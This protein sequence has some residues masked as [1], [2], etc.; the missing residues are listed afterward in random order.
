[1]SNPF[2]DF[3]LIRVVHITL[4]CPFE[5]AT[6]SVLRRSL[7]QTVILVRGGNNRRLASFAHFQHILVASSC[8][9]GK[10]SPMEK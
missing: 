4:V 6:R 3:V 1:M 7:L 8:V 5:S 10:I 2:I 9:H